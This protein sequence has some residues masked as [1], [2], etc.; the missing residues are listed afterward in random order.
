MAGMSG[1]W[2]NADDA[3]LQ[4]QV[5][6]V[7]L[8]ISSLEY[9]ANQAASSDGGVVLSFTYQPTLSDP[10]NPP[11]PRQAR[12]LIIEHAHLDRKP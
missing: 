10:D 8:M 6:G 9:L 3:T 4:I 1:Q 2:L 11:E 7:P 12:R 5:S